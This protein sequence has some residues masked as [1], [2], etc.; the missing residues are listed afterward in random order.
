MKKR[1]KVRR[2]ELSGGYSIVQYKLKK[3]LDSHDQA[4]GLIRFQSSRGSK[5]KVYPSNTP[6][7]SPSPKISF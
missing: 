1:G 4:A 2:V 3:L 7:S 5:G 6:G